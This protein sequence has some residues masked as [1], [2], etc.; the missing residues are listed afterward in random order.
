MLQGDNGH[1]AFIPYG[2]TL[3]AEVSN[4]L[5]ERP[6]HVLPS[7]DSGIN[8]L[9]PNNLLLERSL[10]KNPVTIVY[11]TLKQSEKCAYIKVHMTLGFLGV[12]KDWLCLCRQVGIWYGWKTDAG[13]KVKTRNYRLS[14]MIRLAYD[15][16]PPKPQKAEQLW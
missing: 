3:S 15:P 16:T 4:I 9:T 2:N 6:L 8:I 5:N 7:N 14:L 12:P 11:K 10:S 13:E 1:P